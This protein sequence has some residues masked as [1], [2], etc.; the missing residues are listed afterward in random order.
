MTKTNTMQLAI[1]LRDLLEKTHNEGAAGEPYNHEKKVGD[2]S[3][4]IEKA[5]KDAT[6]IE[7]YKMYSDLAHQIKI[8]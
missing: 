8:A 6:F 7:Q 2:L 3:A 5:A 1:D 4:L